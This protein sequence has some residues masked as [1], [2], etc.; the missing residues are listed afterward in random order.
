[1][2]DPI[3][4]QGREHQVYVAKRDCLLNQLQ[5]TVRCCRPLMN[6]DDGGIDNTPKDWD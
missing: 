1:M 4:A 3:G 2:T 5:T 6:P